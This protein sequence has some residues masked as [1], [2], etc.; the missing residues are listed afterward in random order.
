MRRLKPYLFP[1]GCVLLYI[2][3]FLL[4]YN[5]WSIW[6]DEGYSVMLTDGSW[7]N[8]ITATARDVHPPLYYLLLKS[9]SMVIGESL[10][11]MRALSAC[12]MIGSSVTV[13]LF[14]RRFIGKKQ[15]MWVLPVVLFGPVTIRYGQEMRMYAL[16][17]MLATAATWLFIELIRKNFKGYKYILGLLGYG[18]LI[19]M[20]MYAHYFASLVVVAHAITLL[21][22]VA[23]KS[24]LNIKKFI[25]GIWAQKWLIVPFVL[26]AL[27]YLPWLP[28]L[29]EQR[30]QI[31]EYFWIPK[32]DPMT[33][34]S[35]I[36]MLFVYWQRWK[37]WD[38][39]GIHLVL[40]L[41]S[42][43]ITVLLYGFLIVSKKIASDIKALFLT[44]MAA[45]MAILF[46]MSLGE[47]PLYYD[48]YLVTFAPI[49]YAGL[50]IG[51][52]ELW[53][54]RKK[55]IHHLAVSVM[56]L[57]IGL[58]MLGNVSAY[59]YGNNFGRPSYDSFSMKS[60]YAGVR[61]QIEPSD[62]IIGQSL[63]TY[64]DARFYATRDGREE[65]MLYAP[66]GVTMYGNTGII[67][68]RPDIQL[69]D[70]NTLDTDRFWFI[71]DRNFGI[72]DDY[73]PSAWLVTD[74]VVQDGYAKATLIVRP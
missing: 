51:L 1:A 2:V 22:Y 7:S 73:F 44:Y 31:Q 64:F 11:A 13:A 14:V 72:R 42:V 58:L 49:F 37:I 57:F 6:H 28:V 71:T 3:I 61:D 25:L 36:S 68:L 32:V 54:R 70:V 9:W 16:T 56:V 23:S 27:A 74:T 62:A 45:P 30:Q 59:K 40:T 10:L 35:T 55:S 8:L 24:R 21:I 66:G 33:L 67:Y 5:R 12:L 4:S 38:L 34:V 41:L 39:T 50:A 65:P 48:R 18:L 26:A 60:V 63:G 29:N 46:V 69:K 19:V 52:Y 20:I 47:R 17:S 53:N 43:A 15:A